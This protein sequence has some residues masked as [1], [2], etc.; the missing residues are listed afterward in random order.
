[1]TS[2]P[3]WEWLADEAFEWIEKLKAE[4]A[5]LR[6]RETYLKASESTLKTENADLKAREKA[7]ALRESEF[8]R[9]AKQRLVEIYKLQKQLDNAKLIVD[10]RILGTMQIMGSAQPQIDFT[11][12]AKRMR[13]D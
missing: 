5:D 9:L 1:M 11:R 3:T 6:A 4:N 13:V 12:P 7:S 8:R 2:S 10:M